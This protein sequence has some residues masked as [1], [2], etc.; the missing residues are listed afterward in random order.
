MGQFFLTHHL[1]TCTLDDPTGVAVGQSLH[2]LAGG[3]YTATR[4]YRFPG[5]ETLDT[6]ATVGTLDKAITATATMNG[7]LPSLL[8]T[9]DFITATLQPNGANSILDTGMIHLSTGEII[10]WT[11]EHTYSTGL[12][13]AESYMVIT[14]YADVMH[15]TTDFSHTYI[16]SVVPEPS[17]YFLLLVGSLAITGRRRPTDS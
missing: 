12:S 7:Q 10:S 1:Y 17:T 13:L 6:V 4:T 3:N 14:T 15:S 9:V 11:G 2:T 5:S 8:G 16:S